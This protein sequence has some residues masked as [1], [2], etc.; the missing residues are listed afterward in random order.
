MCGIAGQFLKDA[1]APVAETTLWRMVDTMKNRGPD[2]QAVWTAPGI[3]LAHARLSI[4]DLDPRSHQPF[5]DADTGNV[6]VYNG[7]IYNYVE[8]RQELVAK[9]YTF[10]TTSDTEV[11]LKAYQVWGPDCLNRFNGMW[12]F[13]LYDVQRQHLFCARDRFGI[14]PFV[15]A[16]QNGDLTFASETKTILAACPELGAPNAP[17]LQH[18][19]ATGHFAGSD[20]TFVAGIQNLLPGHCFTV[21]HGEAPHV[22][23]YYTWQPERIDPLPP[24]GELIEQF[25]DLLKD[26]I[27]LRFRSDVPVGVSLSGGLD[28]SSIVA[29]AH[30]LFD[31]P[32][33]TFSCLYPEDPAINEQPYVEAVTKKFATK[34]HH[35]QPK[36]SNLLEL[37]HKTLWEQD[38]PTG[39]PAVLSQRSVMAAAHGN[40]TVL[41]DGQGADEVLGGY[42]DYYRQ[43]LQT[44]MRRF[45][46]WPTPARW[47]AYTQAVDA[48]RQNTRH[49]PLGD[50]NLLRRASRDVAF[51]AKPYGETVLNRV[52]PLEGDDLSTRLLEDLLYAKLPRLLHYEDR[53]SMAFSLES[54]LPF[55]DYRLV[56]FAFA[57]PH[58][59][60]IQNHRTKVLLREA[61]ADRLPSEV[62]NRKEK[63]GYA[64]PGKRW[65]QDPALRNELGHFVERPPAALDLVDRAKLTRA[66]QEGTDE[67]LLWRYMTT[68]LWVSAEKT[69]IPRPIEETR[70]PAA[71]F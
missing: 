29:L 33:E 36:E 7:E 48:I 41:L 59:L 38:G 42:E 23:R 32:V 22:K 54:R 28:S 65:F 69:S 19:I 31:T 15:Y 55:L 37:I 47:Q 13:A 67:M 64:T 62:L 51:S 2:H 9:G 18:F 17:F 46:A 4:L 66:W 63:L 6:I 3:G 10:H 14:K 12:A 58:R 43:S 34:A 21:R 60:K 1:D 50:F 71:I 5:V 27:R 30:E 26:A 40:V 61:M 25:R 16:F 53:N 11:I 49:T 57:L 52:D 24:D 8:L 44:L 35:T 20:Q 70:A 39:T 68:C 56:E 45:L